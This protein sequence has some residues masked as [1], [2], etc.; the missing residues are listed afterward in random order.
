MLRNLRPITSLLLG[1]ALLLLGVGLLT[2]LLPLRGRALGYSATMLGGLTSAYYVGYFAGTFMLPSLIQRIGHIRAFA[3]CTAS[4]ACL[5][6]LHVLSTNAWL[7]LLL[8]LLAGVAL[9]GL[10]A[11]IESWLIAQT[12]PSRRG[13]VFAIYM[14]VNL[15]SLAVAQQLLRIQGAP[16]VLL[17]MVALLVCAATLPVVATRQAQPQLQPV[18]RLELRRLF[19]L[20]PSAGAGALLSGLSMG[21]FWGLL[22][23]YVRGLGF[24]LTQVGTYMSVAILGG[25]AL[26]WPLGRLSDRNDRRLTLAAVCALAAVLA[27]LH[28]AVAAWLGAMLVLIFLYG[29]LTFAVYPIV[30]AHLVDH[31]AQD[32]L[33]SASSSVLLVYGAGSAI[34]PIAAGALMSLSGPGALFV[35]FALTQAALAGYAAFRYWHFHRARST[36]ANFRMMVRTTPTAFEM[37]PE[38]D[39][40]AESR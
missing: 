38:S 4:V 6:L 21:A 27:L 23:V 7:W 13:T 30:V 22:P 36:D 15:G 16:F 25:A 20:A 11:I 8:R 10:Y 28:L 39:T 3:F 9:V 37:L 40:P 17:V 35:W 18:P 1:T 5:V 14:M 24:D 31:L 34:G 33:L 19:A 12:E 26:Q 2:T 32:E 29:G